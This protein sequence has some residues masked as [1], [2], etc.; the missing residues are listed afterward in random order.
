MDCL[1]LAAC[2]PVQKGQPLEEELPGCLH[3]LRGVARVEWHYVI[4]R[5]VPPFPLIVGESLLFLSHTLVSEP[6]CSKP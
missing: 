3:S 2:P 4:V 6:Q 1:M 5:V